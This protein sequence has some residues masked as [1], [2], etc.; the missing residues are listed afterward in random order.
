MHVTHLYNA[1]HVP[2]AFS[3]IGGPASVIYLRTNRLVWAVTLRRLVTSR[4]AR[5]TWRNPA[6]NPFIL[7][8]EKRSTIESRYADVAFAMSNT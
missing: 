6:E 8:D 4:K 7:R 2:H 1:H 5:F 3:C